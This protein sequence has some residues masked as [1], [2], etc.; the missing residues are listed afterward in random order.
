MMVC[1]E[2]RVAQL[3][4]L[5]GFA[6]VAL[7][8]RG[9]PAPCARPPVEDVCTHLSVLRQGAR[10]V[11]HDEIG[12]IVGGKAC[13]LENAAGQGRRGDGSRC[14]PALTVRLAQQ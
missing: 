8:E 7:P 12:M 13:S 14:P 11:R 1:D 2:R 4:W 9:G 5:P 3:G 6:A 10:P